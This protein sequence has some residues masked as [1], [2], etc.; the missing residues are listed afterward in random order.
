MGEQKSTI[1]YIST[2]F[3]VQDRYRA[4][5]STE[6]LKGR[7]MIM[8]TADFDIR[9]CLCVGGWDFRQSY[10]S[11]EQNPCKVAAYLEA[12]CNSGRASL[13]LPPSFSFEYLCC[14]GTEY[15]LLRWTTNAEFSIPALLP[16][17]HY[18]GPTVANTDNLCKCNTVVYSLVSACG[19]CQGG[20]W[21]QCVID[22]CS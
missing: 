17:N 8:L 21:I 2:P 22:S 4:R 13:F 9:F 1:I 11:L 12:V 15:M 5:S 20:E 3:Q 18:T 16:D 10:N 7:I 14:S 6:A 19:G